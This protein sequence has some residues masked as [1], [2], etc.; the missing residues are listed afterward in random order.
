MRSERCAVRAGRRAVHA[1]AATA[2][3]AA[4]AALSAVPRA[5][6]GA[7]PERASLPRQAL[8]DLG[9]LF[10]PRS[11]WILATGAAATGLAYAVEDPDAAADA[12]DGGGVD[13]LSDV[14][15]VYGSTYVLGGAALGA[16]T[17]GNAFEE[18]RL[19]WTGRDALEAIALSQ[20]IVA[21]MKVLVDRERPDGDQYSFPSGHTANAVCVV[22]ILWR[23]Y[24]AGVGAAASGLAVCT[25]LGRMEERRHYLSDVVAGATIGF[26][27]GDV[28]ARRAGEEERA[29]RAAGMAGDASGPEA[30]TTGRPRPD[31]RAPRIGI[32]PRAISLSWRW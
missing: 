23:A 27:I 21:P 13:A 3:L 19:A 32:S 26:L 10:A 4:L 25:A 1:A 7:P 6:L 2:A 22:P 31:R 30:A 12:L 20:A 9:S 28:I 18:T 16:W 11:V 29:A 8:D 14:G 15:N 17:L 5:A 24:G